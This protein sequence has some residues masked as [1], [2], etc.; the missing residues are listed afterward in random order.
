MK[1]NRSLTAV[2]LLL[3]I[4]ITIM[5]PSV[6]HASHGK[7]A[8]PLKQLEVYWEQ[9]EQ[10]FEEMKRTTGYWN[11]VSLD[12]GVPIKPRDSHSA[13]YRIQIPTHPF[14][15]E[16]MLLNKVYGF[17]IQVFAEDGRNL[18]SSDRY[19]TYDVNQVLVPLESES[20][21]KF[22]YVHV[23]SPSDRIGIQVP[24]LIG[25]HQELMTEF[26]GSGLMD[27]VLG[28][29]LVFMAAVMMVSGL[30][31]RKI[32]IPSWL[33]LGLVILSI[34]VLLISYSPFTY[35]FISDKGVF[36]SLSFDLALMT[37][38]PSLSYYFENIFDINRQSLISRF[39]RFQ[40][41]YSIFCFILLCSQFV[42]H[43][44]YYSVYHFF[45]VTMLGLVV[46]IQLG[47][48][49]FYSIRYALHK[50]KDA[51]LF[52]IGFSFFALL[53]VGEL[54]WFVIQD[55]QYELELWK[56]GAI[57][58]IS[59]MIVILGKII[60][61]NH[62]RMTR[63]TKELEMYNNELQHSEKME[64]VSELAASVAHEV[65][66]PLQVTR[67]F[68]QLI[69]SKAD[70]RERKY[71][72]LALN[73]LDRASGIITDFL[74]FAKPELHDLKTL[75][76]ADELK[77][78]EGIL[79]P[80]ANMQGASIT[81]DIPE[82]LHICGNSS[83]FKQA[84]INLVKNSI[85]AVQVDGSVRIWAYK[86]AGSVHIHIKDNG[87]GMCEKELAR[88]GEPYFTNKLQGTGLGLLVTYRIIEVMKGSLQFSSEKGVGTE[89]MLTFPL[90]RC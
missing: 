73:E 50:Y 19:Y 89:V 21:S 56:W 78:I 49:M 66:N 72:S 57:G 84:F 81:L 90:I 8:I 42:I 68:L 40:T 77:H 14:Q 37:L 22:I 75:K 48:L 43:I 10:S 16:G 55:G 1:I 32:Y 41:G 7:G 30:F 25:E 39:R 74:T 63:Y 5:L 85:E 59:C 35:T 76:I 65:R 44:K 82:D 26:V 80:L 3:L 38:L 18:Y 71:L 87:V 4:L 70:V 83:K 88:L 9:G 45:T 15:Q 17:Q 6:V 62:D 46:A 53:T 2:C 28:I 20:E 54:I 27:V 36:A 34:G 60:T 12:E 24:P 51:L 47:I 69:S 13:W 31:L 67:G 11:P 23:K 33:S 58:F 64:M 79:S 61:Q 29:G 86:Q 52:T